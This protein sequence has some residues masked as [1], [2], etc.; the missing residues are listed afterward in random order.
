MECKA[1]IKSD[2]KLPPKCQVCHQ[3]ASIRHNMI[4]KETCVVCVPLEPLWY[5]KSSNA[6]V[7]RTILPASDTHIQGQFGK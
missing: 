1:Q 7:N 5:I 6:N 3:K 2:E 4:Q